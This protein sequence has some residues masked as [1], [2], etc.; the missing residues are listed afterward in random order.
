MY[1]TDAIIDP[2]AKQSKIV[3]KKIKGDG[4]VWVEAIFQNKISGNKRHYFV[5]QNT[6]QRV[7]N[8]PPT[9]ASRVFYLKDDII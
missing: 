6:G 9:G 8:E 1:D 7:R 5:S 3:Q 2:L 4:D